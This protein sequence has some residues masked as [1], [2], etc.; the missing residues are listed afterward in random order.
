[1]LT[2]GLRTEPR[3][4]AAGLYRSAADAGVTI[5]GPEASLDISV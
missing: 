2:E 5:L 4:S 3:A 1:V